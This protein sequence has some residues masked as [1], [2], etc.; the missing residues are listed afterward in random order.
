MDAEHIFKLSQ[1]A[2]Q[3]IDDLFDYVAFELRNGD[4]A[5]KTMRSM[6]DAFENLEYFPRMCP[7]YKG[8]Y[9]KCIIR[10][11]IVALYKID[12]TR[13]EIK[14][15]RVFHTLRNYKIK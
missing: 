13:K 2:K 9:R 7:I 10:K 3:D 14:I 1:K 11:R 6:L 8:G 15:E 4:A 5:E 12:E